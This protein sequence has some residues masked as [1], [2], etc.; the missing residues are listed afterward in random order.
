[1]TATETPFKLRG[2][3]ESAADAALPSWLPLMA[4]RVPGVNHPSPSSAL[5]MEEIVGMPALDAPAWVI[6]KLWP[7]TVMLAVREDV[8][9]LAATE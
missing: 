4:M 6:V 5:E 2:S 8:A 3:G 7:P 1:M 9:V